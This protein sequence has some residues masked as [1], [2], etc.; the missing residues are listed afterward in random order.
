MEQPLAVCASRDVLRNGKPT[1][2]FL[3]Q[4]LGSTPKEA[5]WEW[6][7][8]FKKAYPTHHLEDKVVLEGEKNDTTESQVGGRPKRAKSSPA[9][10]IDYVMG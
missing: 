2:H 6:L 9:W 5:T 4:W 10:H 1:Q 3:V 7:S 8:D